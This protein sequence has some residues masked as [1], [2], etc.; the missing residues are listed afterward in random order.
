MLS[1]GQLLYREYLRSEHWKKLRWE[2]FKKYGYKCCRCASG[3]RVQPHHHTYRSPWTECT[4][5]DLM[6]LCRACH[7]KEHGL[8]EEKVRNRKRSKKWKKM[9]DRKRQSVLD[10]MNHLRRKNFG[11]QHYS[12]STHRPKWTNRDNSSN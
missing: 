7:R 11:V 1:M 6:I 9:I 8:K 3:V 10:K 12:F 5:E 2:A 4:V